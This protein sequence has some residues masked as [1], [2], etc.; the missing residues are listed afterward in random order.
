MRE[1]CKLLIGEPAYVRENYNKYNCPFHD[2]KVPSAIAGK[3]YFTCYG[4]NLKLNYFEFIR[5]FFSLESDDEV[6]QK[7]RELKK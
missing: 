2:D 6:K 5:K 4:C 7:M 3:A 1:L